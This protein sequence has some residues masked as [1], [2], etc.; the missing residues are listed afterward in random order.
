M[1]WEIY[2]LQRKINIIPVCKL[3]R[4]QTDANIISTV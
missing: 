2:Y 1:E 4:L 3:V